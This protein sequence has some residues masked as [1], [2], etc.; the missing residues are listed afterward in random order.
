VPPWRFFLGSLLAL[1]AAG[2]AI[3]PALAA[4]VDCDAGGKLAAALARARPGEKIMVRGLCRENLSIPAGLN[5]VTLDGGGRAAIV[6]PNER[7]PVLTIQGRKI[8]VRGIGLAGGR[9]GIDLLDGGTAV[10]DGVTV[11]DNG[12]A[13]QPGSGIGIHIDRNG[14]AEIVGTTVRRNADAGIVVRAGA[15]RIGRVE[16]DARA[17]TITDNVGAGLV[18]SDKA[19]AEVVGTTISRNKSDGIQVAGGSELQAAD[20]TIEGNNGTGISVSEN[21]LARLPAGK[22]TR[23]PNRTGPAAK[24]SAY[25][26]ACSSGG[27]VEGALGTLAGIKGATNFDASCLNRSTP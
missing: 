4:T 17:N 13:G 8:A 5:D 2:V 1:A 11:E 3:P 27:R 12:T 16:K 23:R 10:I 14:F 20:N 7:Q 18:L 6:A 24:N 21:S 15:A 19:R 9:N 22:G 25:G 26:L